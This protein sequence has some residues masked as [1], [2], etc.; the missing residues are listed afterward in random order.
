MIDVF[1]KPTRRQWLMGATALVAVSLTAPAAHAQS[2]A[3][4]LRYVTG[5]VVND[6]LPNG[7]SLS[8][9]WTCTATGGACGAASGGS[10]GGKTVNLS[11]DIASG[12]TV[13]ISVP[14]TYSTNPAAY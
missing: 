6:A 3:E 5:A 2:R 1:L 9:P 4:T 14:V 10:T 12:G 11:V 7:M 8:G 13:T